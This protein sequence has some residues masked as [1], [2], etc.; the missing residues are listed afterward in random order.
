MNRR[1]PSVCAAFGYWAVLVL[2]GTFVLFVF[3]RHGEFHAG[4]NSYDRS[5]FTDMVLGTAHKPYVQRLL[6]PRTVL[7]VAALTPSEVSEA[8]T[9]FVEN[10]PNLEIA[11]QFLRWKPVDAYL[12]LVAG[13]L[14]LLSLVLFAHYT[15]KMTLRTV[16]LRETTP[17]RLALALLAL[18]CLPPFFRYISYLYDPPQ[19]FLF[20]LSFYLMASGKRKEFLILFPFCCLNKETAILLIPFGFL[21]ARRSGSSREA[22]RMLGGQVLIYAAVRAWLMWEFRSAPG[23]AFEFHL[24]DHNAGFFADG[25]PFVFLVPFLLVA[26]LVALGWREKAYV[27]KA[28]FLCT[29]PP[30]VVAAFFLGFVDEW[31][32]YYEAFPPVFAMIVDTVSR[33]NASLRGHGTSAPQ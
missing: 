15:A 17:S 29:L 4:I 3:V 32:G 11:L 18:L 16:P 2:F 8:C 13:A 9:R 25:W 28:G 10:R 26:T 6:L 22:W 12:Y 23:S 24:M 31:R 1:F 5:R 14:M 19:L 30:L 20:A 21:C 7:I 27:L 33:L